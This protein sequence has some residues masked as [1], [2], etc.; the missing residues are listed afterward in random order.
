MFDD[1]TGFTLAQRPCFSLLRFVS[2]SQLKLGHCDRAVLA[3][4]FYFTHLCKARAQYVKSTFHNVTI[5]AFECLAKRMGNR[6]RAFWR[7][8]YAIDQVMRILALEALVESKRF[9]TCEA[10]QVGML[11]LFNREPVTSQ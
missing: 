5:F 1:V 8:L 9:Q 2:F 7:M 4:T 3:I 6:I 10:N 11:D